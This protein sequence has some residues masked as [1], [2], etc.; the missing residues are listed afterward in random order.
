MGV[1]EEFLLVDADGRLAATGPELSIAVEDTVDEDDG[2]V[3][4]ELRR[5]QVE[6]ATPVCTT[7]DDVFTALR[8]LRD[9]LAAE[10]ARDDLRLLPSGTAPLPDDRPARVTPDRRYRRMA[11]QFG[12]LARS[13]LICGTHVHIGIPDEATGLRISNHVRPW[14][15]VLLALTANSPFQDGVDTGHA[16]WRH[17][18]C[19]RWPSAGPPPHVDSV[20]DYEAR[21]AGLLE[22]GAA[23]DP[24]MLYW[25]VRLSAHQ[26]TVEVR[27]A[28]VVPT[29]DEAVMLAVL[30]RAIAN[31]ALDGG[32]DCGGAGLPHEV[33]RARLWRSSRDGLAGRCVDPRTG[34]LAPAWQVVDG[35]VD[36]VRPWLRS[37]GDEDVVVSTLEWLRA[38][39]GGADRQRALFDRDHRLTDVV[40]GLAWS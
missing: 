4:H 37:T 21:L 39:G 38:D 13:M 24:G 3:Q 29:V 20:D 30:V 1:E 19:K 11:R 35:F 6:S 33:L 23:L 16:S 15:P 8:G 22:A 25:D 2:Q 12:P 17:E 9:R 10:A 5:C 26:P 14:L 40:D 31:R 27:I 28:D 34:R 36:T 7:A 18:L 32:S